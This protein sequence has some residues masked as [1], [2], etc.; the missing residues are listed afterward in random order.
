MRAADDLPR[1]ETSR[2]G[3]RGRVV[4]VVAVVL[5]IILGT[6]LQGIA[7]FYTDY[8]WFEALD[9]AAVWRQ[10]LGAKIV[11]TLIFGGIFFLFLWLNLFLSDR[12]APALRPAGPEEEL[13]ARYHDV[14]AGRAGLIRTVVSALFALIA[15]AGV[16]S[17]WE[18]W[19]LYTNRQDFGIIAIY[20]QSWQSTLYLVV[21]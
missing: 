18:E 6:S 2:F 17:H 16:S 19:L 11:L 1:R 21:V 7:G 5:V 12:A 10:I 3:G 13:L 14:V 4:A 9:R 15:A 20:D 8:L